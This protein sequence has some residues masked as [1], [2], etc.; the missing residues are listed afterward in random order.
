MFQ[1]QLSRRLVSVV[2]G[3]ILCLP[4]LF[5]QN[6]VVKGIVVDDTDQGVIGAAVMIKG[7]TNGIAT[8]VD[9]KFEISCKPSDVLVISSVGYDNQEVTV[10]NKTELRIVLSISQE[11]LDD[12]V[13]IG[14]GTT[15]A[16]NFTGSVDV[17][18][19]TDSPV[20]DLGLSNL[21]DML[22]GRLSGVVFGAESPT[23]GGNASIRVRGRRSIASTSS[24]PL[25][26]VNGVI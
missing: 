8:D 18:K 16:K 4:L 10:G 2:C 26:V 20:A 13:V 14:Y 7:T 23:V 11:L 22:R 1:T 9:G 24:N 12:V 17:L 21:A 19:M 6:K 5:A 15:R 3:F 25:L